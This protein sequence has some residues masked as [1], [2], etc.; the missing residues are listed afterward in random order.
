[1]ELA[2]FVLIVATFAA[3]IL[4]SFLGVFLDPE[5]FKGRPVPSSFAPFRE[6]C[7]FGLPNWLLRPRLQKV[8]SSQPQHQ[9]SPDTPGRSTFSLPIAR[10]QTP[11]SFSV[12]RTTADKRESVA[13]LSVRRK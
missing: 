7:R 5:Q 6:R 11:E 3:L 4:P 10:L 12:P 2:L 8:C 13:S 1:M 9:A